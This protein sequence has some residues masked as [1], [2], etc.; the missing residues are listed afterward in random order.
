MFKIIVFSNNFRH[1]FQTSIIFL[2]S[3]I[4]TFTI[5]APNLKNIQTSG[6]SQSDIDRSESSCGSEI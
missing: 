5:F 6:T 3:D 1:I 4:K 2:F